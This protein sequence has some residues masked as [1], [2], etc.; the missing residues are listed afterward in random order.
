LTRISRRAAITVGCAILALL[1]VPLPRDRTL[2]A[3]GDLGHAPIFGLLALALYR[4]LRRRSGAPEWAAVGAA[5]ALALGAGGL[6]ELV[7]AA[8]GRRASL[9]DAAA[10]AF[11]AAAALAWMFG[12]RAAS[13]RRRRLLAAASLGAL[14]LASLEPVLNLVDT[15]AQRLEMPRLAS[16]E[17]PLELSR[18]T[19][20][21]SQA[22][23]TAG[24]HTHGTRGLRLDLRPGDFPGATLVWPPP[25]WTAW[26]SLR[27]D[28]D[29]DT[30]DPIPLTVRVEDAWYRPRSADVFETVV[31][32]SSGR[33]QICVA[34]SDVVAGP[35]VRLLD[36][37]RVARLELYVARLSQ[38]RSLQLDYLRLSERQCASGT[39]ARAERGPA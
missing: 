24:Y 20:Y 7:Q 17:Q 23:R 39:P 32:L 11:G 33:H 38:P 8:V 18:W 12:V 5:F 26:Q 13:A 19:F 2:Q 10:D 22:S 34:L 29:L 6:I 9:R 27:V 1:L 30:G 3:I 35:G 14:G 37:H 25:D 36:L 21:G 16:F 4:Q 28:V 31:P 15:A